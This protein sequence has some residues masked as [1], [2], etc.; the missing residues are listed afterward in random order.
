MVK[1]STDGRPLVSVAS[2]GGAA[3][4]LPSV[5]TGWRP[6]VDRAAVRRCKCSCII[7]THSMCPVCQAQEAAMKTAQVTVPADKSCAA[8]TL[9]DTVARRLMRCGPQA[10]DLL[11]LSNHVSSGWV[12]DR[13][14]VSRW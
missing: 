12:S 11:S 1:V 14:G 5:E 10:P 3:I 8:P 4:G 9:G 2:C 6:G 7:M 13:G